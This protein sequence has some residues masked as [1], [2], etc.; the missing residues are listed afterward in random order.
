[1][2]ISEAEFNIMEL[3]WANGG[4][5]QAKD[6]AFSLNRSMALSTTTVYTMLSRLIKKGVVTR[7][8]PGF[9]C[10]ATIKRDD[11]MR[12]DTDH[13][14]TKFYDGSVYELITYCIKLDRLSE[15]DKLRLKRLVKDI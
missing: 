3:I 12:R 9:Y 5:M 15:N 10:S 4:T 11:V 1:M 8:D 2:S 6:I 7:H 14:I 13:L